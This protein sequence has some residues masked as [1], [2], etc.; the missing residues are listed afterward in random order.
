MSNLEI[1][2]FSFS[3]FLLEVLSEKAKKMDF[4]SNFVA[5]SEYMKFKV[6]WGLKLTNI[7]PRMIF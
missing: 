4:F 5:I 7:S 1:T 3:V 2:F 6:I